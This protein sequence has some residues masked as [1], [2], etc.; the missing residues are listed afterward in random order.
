MEA[1]KQE[2][3]DFYN[4]LRNIELQ[5]N[6]SNYKYLNSNV[7]FYS[8]VRKSQNFF[9]DW[10][11]KS[12]KNKKVLDYGCGNGANVLFLA[13]NGAEAIGIDISD[14]S[15]ENCKKNAIGEGLDKNATFFVM[16]AEKMEFDDDYFDVI[17]C[18]GVL[19][20][21]DIRK[22]Y[23]ELARV[24]KPEGKIICVEPLAYNPLIQLYRRLTPHLRTKWEVEHILT[25]KDLKIASYYFNEI[26]YKF[27]HLATL[28]AVPFRNLPC[29]NQTL[30]LMESID[31]ALLRLPVIQRMGWQIIFILSQ[32]NKEVLSIEN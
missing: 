2:Q 25:M 1:R 26:N 32:P 7:K 4:K 18:A 10:L 8:V 15:I 31:D 13:K 23:V 20:H 21:L 27:F 19:H 28:A 6:I 3:I 14:E 11:L 22:A 17:I 16:D 30:G 5:K 29:F 9:K 12:C 24:L